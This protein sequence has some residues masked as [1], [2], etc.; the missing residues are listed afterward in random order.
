MGI[1]VLLRSSASATRTVQTAKAA[2]SELTLALVSER[3]HDDSVRLVLGSLAGKQFIVTIQSDGEVHAESFGPPRHTV[4]A[5]RVVIEA[6]LP[7]ATVVGWNPSW[8]T[9]LDDD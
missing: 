3:S 5:D 1:E 4:E 8:D 2:A 7:H 9:E 6:L